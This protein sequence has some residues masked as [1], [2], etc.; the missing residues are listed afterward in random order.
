MRT[1]ML[2]YHLM[3]KE[4]RCLAVTQSQGNKHKVFPKIITALCALFPRFI[5]RSPHV[6]NVTD[7][8]TKEA[9]SFAYLKNACGLQWFLSPIVCLS[10]GRTL[11]DVLHRSR[12]TSCKS[13]NRCGL[14]GVTPDLKQVWSTGFYSQSKIGVVYH[15]F[16]SQTKIKEMRSAD[17]Y[18]Q[19]KLGVVYWFLLKI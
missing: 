8:N 18:S 14:L 5:L 19:S 10:V 1:Q 12:R 15:G 3:E 17:V 6:F 9:L 2:I 11:N 4:W 13:E 16:Y 7:R